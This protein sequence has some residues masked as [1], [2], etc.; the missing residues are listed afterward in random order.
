[1]E[2]NLEVHDLTKRFGNRTVVDHLSFSVRKGEAYGILGHNGA[3]KTTAIESILGLHKLDEGNALIL[4]EH[5]KEKRKTL[6]EH[7][8]VQLQ[9]SS[10]PA[11][12]K[13][14]EICEEM[15]ALYK[16]PADYHK[17]LQQFGMEQ[18]ES[19]MIDK[20]SGGEKQKLSVI[21]ALLSNPDIIFLDELTTGLDVE[22]RRE[23]WEI[24]KALKQKGITI[25]LTTHYMEEAEYLCDRI[26]LM[27]QGKKVIEG[28]VKEVISIHKNLEEAYLK[29]MKE[30]VE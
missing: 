16:E 29:H 1:M 28:T 27:K 22:A 9:A 26:L 20:L 14:K 11:N 13:V 12:A 2:Y 30:V 6:F 21:I 10:Y 4:G 19:Q 24:L 18:F 23:V 8:G 7:V 17:L 3:G 25:I 15:S 5:A